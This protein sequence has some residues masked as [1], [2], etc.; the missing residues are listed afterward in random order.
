[1]GES[2]GAAF[3]GIR[4]GNIVDGNEDNAYEIV[5]STIPCLD[6]YVERGVLARVAAELLRVDIAANTQCGVSSSGSFAAAYLNVLRSSGLTRNQEVA[7]MFSGGLQRVARMTV[8]EYEAKKKREEEKE[9][10]RERFR[11]EEEAATA[12]EEEERKK[13]QVQIDP[14]TGV[15]RRIDEDEAIVPMWDEDQDELPMTEEQKINFRAEAILKTVWSEYD[16]R[17]I[18]KQTSRNEFY[19]I[20]REKAVEL[21]RKE[22]NEENESKEKTKRELKSDKTILHRFE[23]QN[24]KQYTK[25]LALERKEMQNQKEISDTWVKYIYLLLEVTMAD[26]VKKNILFHNEDQFS[27]TLLL[28]K[29]AN[30]LRALAHLPPYEVVYDPLDASAIISFLTKDESISVASSILGV[31]IDVPLSDVDQVLAALNSK[32]GKILKSIPAL[33]GASQIIE[34]AIDTLKQELPQPPPSVNEIRRSESTARK[35]AVSDMRLKAIQN[36]GKPA[37]EPN[38]VGK[39]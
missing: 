35:D 34:L 27:Q 30:E 22:I 4:H 28:R 13:Q 12:R 9:A 17:M 32:H 1:M 25:L 39:M 6:T 8:D 29:M 38:P 33:R 14:D 16:A 3:T 7:K 37:E 36:R 23:D 20:N 24:R 11:L 19:D 18:T 21:A 10:E 26:C 15:M 2:A 5:N 31:N